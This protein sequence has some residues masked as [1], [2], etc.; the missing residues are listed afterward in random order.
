M[1]QVTD[2]SPGTLSFSELNE[3]SQQLVEQV[4]AEKRPLVIT[5]DGQAAAVLV[6]AREYEQQLRRLALME[7]ILEGERDFA[8]G[9]THSQE[10]VEALLDQWLDGGE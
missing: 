1:A 6:E 5:R 8:E 9:R 2:T 7:R 10:E 3:Q 4:R